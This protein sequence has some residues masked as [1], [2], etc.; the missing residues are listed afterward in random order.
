MSSLFDKLK[1]IVK[2]NP[3]IYRIALRA[4]ELFSIVKRKRID[5]TGNLIINKGRT[6]SIRIK[7]VGNNNRIEIGKET[8]FEN[9][10]F[11]IYGNNHSFVVGDNCFI[12]G[13]IAW[14]ED[15]GG[16][17]V[18]GNNTTIEYANLALTEHGTK[19]TIGNDCMFSYGIDFRTGDSHSIIEK[20]TKKRI[21]YAKDIVV[22][23][24]V[25]IG[26][27]VKVLK[28]V[29]IHKE[30]VIATGSIVTSDI[31]SNCI[32]GGIPAKVIKDN[33]NWL[34]ERI[35]ENE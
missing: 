34:R 32:A 26:A 16:K 2:K 22:M 10:S 11:Y 27:D 25:W 28:G 18:I 12:K 9:V 8:R 30:S 4:N 31:P 21:N 1:L 24:H 35:Y 19:I 15:D 7:I 29:T 14:Y 6:K 20:D 33:I 5:G 3:L 17:I 13:G 23:D